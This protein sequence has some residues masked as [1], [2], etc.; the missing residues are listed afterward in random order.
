M[1]ILYGI[2]KEEREALR[3]AHMAF[4]TSIHPSISTTIHVH[5]L[6]NLGEI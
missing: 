6:I 4:F 3:Q 5:S 1:Y 2:E